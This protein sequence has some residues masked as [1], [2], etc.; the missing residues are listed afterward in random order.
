MAGAARDDNWGMTTIDVLERLIPGIWVEDLGAG[1][2]IVDPAGTER[3]SYV[4]LTLLLRIDA[5]GLTDEIVELL[6][7]DPLEYILREFGAKER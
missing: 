6:G 2:Y 5:E 1:I 3:T 4:S 7:D